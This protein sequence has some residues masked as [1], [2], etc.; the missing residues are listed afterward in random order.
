[1][2]QKESSN[3][4]DYTG[5]LK[6]FLILAPVKTVIYRMMD[7]IQGNLSGKEPGFLIAKCACQVKIKTEVQGKHVFLSLGLLKSLTGKEAGI[8]RYGTIVK[9]G[10]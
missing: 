1:M 9:N 8:Y 6:L 10:Y 4:M 7:M 5:Y 2:P 3:G